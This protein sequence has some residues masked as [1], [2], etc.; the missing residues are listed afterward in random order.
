MF[1]FF[2]RR[3]KRVLDWISSHDPRSRKYPVRPLL[4]RRISP[5]PKFWQEGVVLDQG[6]EGACVGYGWTA[7]LLA[8]PF[9]PNP[10]PL[11]ADA[12]TYATQ[13]YRRAKLIDQWPGEDYEGTS[14]LAGAKIMMQDG[15]IGG[16]R[17]CFGAS[18][19]R[20]A[21]IALGPVVIG[22]PWYSGMYSTPRNGLVSV[23]GAKVGGH[24]LIIT[25]YHPEYEIDG[26][27]REVFRWRNSWGESYGINGSAFITFDNLA[28]LLKDGGEAC[29]P[30]GRSAPNLNLR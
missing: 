28:A 10:Q 19:V 15:N 20:D 17:W 18:D 4:P 13:A 26:K 29:I 22:V 27:K 23:T 25:G 30:E 14:V 9:S 7:E 6:R 3:P 12:E 11:V 2:Q 24:C 21:V 1:K 8:E 5:R 16:Y